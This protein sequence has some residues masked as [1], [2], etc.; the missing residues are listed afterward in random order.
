MLAGLAACGDNVT[1]TTMNQPDGAMPAAD[2]APHPPCWPDDGQTPMGS[3]HLGTGRARFER[4]PDPLPI[5]FGFQNGFDLIANVKMSG[6][7][8]GNPN[9]V[10][11]PSNPRSRILAFFADTGIPL[12]YYAHC[13]YQIGYVPSPDGD[14]TETLPIGEGIVFESCW[15]AQHLIGKRVRIDLYVVD[16]NGGYATD[17]VTVTL[18]A[19]TGF[20]PMEGPLPG[21]VHKGVIHPPALPLPAAQ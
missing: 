13:P 11:D 7:D 19:P 6:L 1:G 3:V 16:R 9:D 15:R 14:S 4:M 21:C 2:A 18:A 12:N 5:E 10:L 20:Y 8:P 17:S